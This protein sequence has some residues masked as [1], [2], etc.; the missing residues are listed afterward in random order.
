MLI[1]IACTYMSLAVALTDDAR[2]DEDGP[3]KVY[4]VI[5]TSATQLKAMITLYETAKGDEADFWHAPSVV[6]STIDV[7]VSPSFTNKFTS[8]LKSHDFPF[9]VAIEDLKKNVL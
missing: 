5:P 6:N 1:W 9:H 3:F 2:P 4:R 7:M 8:F